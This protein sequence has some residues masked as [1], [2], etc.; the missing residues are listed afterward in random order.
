[1]SISFKRS[2]QKVIANEFLLFWLHW[3]WI[4]GRSTS[5][6][7]TPLPQ[8]R[9]PALARK[10][11]QT[12]KELR[13]LLGVRHQLCRVNIPIWCWCKPMYNTSTQWS[14]I[15]NLIIQ[16]VPNPLPSPGPGSH[17]LPLRSSWLAFWYPLCP[18]KK[19]GNVQPG[20]DPSCSEGNTSG[21]RQINKLHLAGCHP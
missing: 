10:C 13:F 6:P 12:K 19:H 1:M 7:Y 9:P 15:I 18:K 2:L 11:C 3:I 16:T 21:K 8:C 20:A 14:L 17:T 4:C 5:W